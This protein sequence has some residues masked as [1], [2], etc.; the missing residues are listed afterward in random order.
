MP[1]EAGSIIENAAYDLLGLYLLDQVSGCSVKM[2]H[3]AYNHL[4]EMVY[5]NIVRIAGS[6]DDDGYT[7]VDHALLTLFESIGDAKNH[8][9]QVWQVERYTPTA[10]LI[11]PEVFNEDGAC[12]P[13]AQWGYGL[14]DAL[15]RK[16]TTVY[17]DQDVTYI[18][19]EFKRALQA[20]LNSRDD[21]KRIT[22]D[23]ALS[24]LLSKQGWLVREDIHH[25]SRKISPH[26][27]RI[28][29][30]LALDNR[31]L[32]PLLGIAS[33]DRVSVLPSNVTP[34]HRESSPIAEPTELETVLPV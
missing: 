27:K 22:S 11:K 18:T 23:K 20:V 2:E 33:I 6:S 24:Q 1:D 29:R 31:K 7:S 3:E 5:Q 30:V 8:D 34:L 28:P 15:D 9:G 25:A 17:I 13:D 21:V 10:Q 12:Y 16:L 4:V 32:F 19:G 14:S 26:G